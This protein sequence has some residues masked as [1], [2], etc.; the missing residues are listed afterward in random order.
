VVIPDRPAQFVP[1]AYAHEPLCTQ[2]GFTQIGCYALPIGQGAGFYT[3]HQAIGT[4]AVYYNQNPGCSC[5]SDPWGTQICAPLS[6][7]PHVKDNDFT[8][9]DGGVTYKRLYCGTVSGVH[10]HRR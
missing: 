2:T 7:S 9:T 4:G 10:L 1:S 5:W 3:G 8:Y 6:R